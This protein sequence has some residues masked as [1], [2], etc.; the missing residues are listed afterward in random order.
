MSTLYSI[1]QMNQLGDALEAFG[2]SPDEVTKLRSY[3]KL[4]DVKALLHGTAEIVIAKHLIDCDASPFLPKGWKVEE[5]HKGGQLEWNSENI[6]LYLSEKQKNGSFIEGNKLRQE[7]QDQPVLNANV[8]DYL[9]AN[10]NLI[11]EEWKGK[12]ICFWGTIY[13]NGNG[14][15]SVRYLNWYGEQWYWYYY[16]LD[17]YFSGYLPAAVGK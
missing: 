5:H 3:A 12:Y 14:N 17:S 16:S 6:A 15:L 8:L 1:G 2:F 7:L 13:R 9:L 4:G 10:P 11:P